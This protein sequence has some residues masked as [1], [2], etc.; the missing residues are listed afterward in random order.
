MGADF[1]RE[2]RK[3]MSS[4]ELAEARVAWSISQM[5]E[6][7][8]SL[9]WDRYGDEFV[10]FAMEEDEERGAVLEQSLGPARSSSLGSHDPLGSESSESFIP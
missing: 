4:E 1:L 5:L 8:N 10:A 2:R 9:L 7:L 6:E 3:I